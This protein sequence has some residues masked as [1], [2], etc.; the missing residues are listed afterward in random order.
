MRNGKCNAQCSE[1]RAITTQRVTIDA[2]PMHAAAVGDLP[3]HNDERANVLQD[4][5]RSRAAH[6]H[7]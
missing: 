7:R 6:G 2:L 1:R 5:G 4:P 3:E